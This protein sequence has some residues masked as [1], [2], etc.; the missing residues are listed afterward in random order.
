MGKPNFFDELLDWPCHS[1][2]DRAQSQ[3]CPGNG[4]KAKEASWLPEGCYI[5]RAR[6][7]WAACRL[8][9]FHHKHTL[10]AS[11][12]HIALNQL[13][14]RILKDPSV[15]QLTH[16]HVVCLKVSDTDLLCWAQQSEPS[17]PS[18]VTGL[19]TPEPFTRLQPIGNLAASVLKLAPCQLV[20]LI[21][22]IMIS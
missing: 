6:A 8:C 12:D 5:P 11:N 9:G 20:W 4:G 3:C 7:P 21:N 2:E 15:M 18:F 19:E 13:Q 17:L 1:W 16:L 10:I 22:N 14:S